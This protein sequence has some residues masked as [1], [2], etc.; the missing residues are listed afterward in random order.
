MYID[1]ENWLQVGNVLKGEEG[2]LIGEYFFRDLKLNPD[3]PPDTF[4]R[5]A[6][7]R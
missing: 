7:K 5:E 1:K 6:L 3:F 4:T 2:R